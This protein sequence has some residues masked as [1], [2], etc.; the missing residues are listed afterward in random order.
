MFVVLLGTV[1]TL[2]GVG[3]GV[4]V[5]ATLLAALVSSRG[6]LSKEVLKAPIEPEQ[7]H[8]G[9][10]QWEVRCILID[11]NVADQL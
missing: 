4:G 9:T 7:L 8:E 1:V 6:P 10:E 3:V 2:L 11:S 5:V